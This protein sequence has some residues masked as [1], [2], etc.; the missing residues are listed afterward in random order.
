MISELSQSL[1]QY[2]KTA[3]DVRKAEDS[4]Q[5]DRGYFLSRDYKQLEQ[6]EER[7]LNSLFYKLA[8]HKPK[9]KNNEGSQVGSDPEVFRG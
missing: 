6:A 8:N 7:F 5:Y 2:L 1:I 9:G 3:E 4:C